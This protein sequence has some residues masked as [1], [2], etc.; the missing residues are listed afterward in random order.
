[1][2]R[3]KGPIHTI[4]YGVSSRD[5]PT[6]EGE[7]P[8]PSP[9]SGYIAKALDNHPIMRFLGSAG[10]AIL[11]TAVG[12]K[13]LKSGGLK[14]GMALEDSSR[15]AI[16]GGRTDALPTRLVKGIQE[17][18]AGLDELQSVARSVNGVDNPYERLVYEVDGKLTSGYEGIRSET[19]FWR[20]ISEEGAKVSGVGQTG[21][22]AEVWMY[23]DELQKRLVRAGRRMPYELPALYI[24]Q[25]GVTEPLFGHN[26]DR[27]K[28]NW[29][30]PADVVTD[31]VKQSTMNLATM[32]LPFEAL[33]A[34]GTAGKSSLTTFANS[35]ND[36]KALSPI[37]RKASNLAVDLRSLLAE[38]GQDS[39]VI[40]NKALKV[41]SRTS[42]AFATGVQAARDT[43]PEFVQALHSARHGATEAARSA[44]EKNAGKLKILTARAKG[45]F[46][47]N[48]QSDFGA[49]DSIPTFKGLRT[50]FKAAAEDF[51]T[52][53]VA[54]DVVSGKMTERQALSQVIERFSSPRQG[55][56]DKVLGDNK[57]LLRSKGMD[58]TDADRLLQNGINRIQAQHSS[59]LSRLAE[60]FHGLGHG[61]P[62]S[63]T[64]TTSEFFLKR[65]QD[66]YKDQLE[67]TLIRKNNIDPKAANNFVNNINIA[68]LPRQKTST[69]ITKRITLGRK[70]IQADGDEFF[71]DI[72][73]RFSK[74]KGGKTFSESIGEGSALRQSLER[75]DR[76]FVS[77][78]FQNGLRLDITKKW[79][80]FY[81]NDVSH[82]TSDIL[83]P[84]K[85]SYSDFVGE[86][87]P[88]KQSY[89]IR[90]T[91]QTLGIKLNEADGKAISETVLSSRIAA[92]GID[93][94]DTSYLRDYL[95]NNKGLTTGFFSGKA[96]L[97]GMKPLLI[98]EGMEAGI[99]NHLPQ[100]HQLAIRQIASAQATR[101]PLTAGLGQVTPTLGQS[102]I[103]GV[104]R[105]SNGSIL[106]FTQLASTLRNAKGFLADEFKLPIIGFN[107]ADM[108]G[109]KSLK[110]I[111]NS[112]PIQYI[113]ARTVQ[114]FLGQQEKQAADYFILA[115]N[116][117]T[118]GVLRSFGTNEQGNQVS[119]TIAGSFR[120]ISSSSSELI[121]KEARN[122]AKLRGSTSDE[123][124][125]ISNRKTRLKSLFDVDEEQPNSLF[126]LYNRF[127]GRQSDIRNTNVMARLLTPGE[128]V[129]YT[130]R[131]IR[132]TLTLKGLQDDVDNING[133]HTVDE[134]NAVVHTQRD[135]LNAVDE[136]RKKT[137]GNGTH[138]N[139]IK[140]LEDDKPNL[141]TSAGVKASDVSSGSDK[142]LRQTY[143]ALFDDQARAASIIKRRGGDPRE[144]TAALSR[145]KSHLGQSNLDSTS[146]LAPRSRVIATRKDEASNEV[147]RYI[148]LKNQML[149]GNA[150]E[151]IFTET[152]KAI[153][154]LQKQGRIGIND[155]IEAEA[156]ALASL[157]N[158]SA[159]A[160][161]KAEQ[162]GLQDARK[163]LIKFAEMVREKPEAA[164][165][166]K[167]Y[168][169]GDIAM[170]N[171]G[172]RRPFSRAM[173]A[174]SRAF[175]TAPYEVDDLA[176]NTLGSGQDH[177]IV[178]TFGTV[179]AKNPM[180]A[181]KSALG[182]GTYNNPES[183]STGSVPVSHLVSRVNKYF[184]TVGMQL[185]QSQYG[186][187]LDLYARGMVGKRILPAVAG[188]AT[189]L[190]ADRVVG[191]AVN[192]KD[193][194]GE[195]VYSPFL[196]TKLARGAVE[197]N[198]VGAG[199]IPGGMNAQEKREQLLNGQVPIKQGRY[200]PLGST[201]FMGG[202]T[203]YYR[204]SYYRKLKEAGTYT[205]D[206][207]GT[208]MEKLLYGYDFSPLRPLDPYRFER[209]HYEDRPYP[210][211]GEYFTGPWGPLN[212]VLNMT[213]GKLLKPQVTMHQ[214]ELAAG[215]ANYQPAGQ[216][217]AYEGSGIA[218]GGR[219]GLG[220][221][222]VGSK[223]YLSNSYGSYGG[224]GVGS[225]YG[226]STLA[227]GNYNSR[228]SSMAGP[229]GSAS[230]Q[231][232]AA[233]GGSNNALRNMAY[234]PPKISG[235]MPPEII[236]AGDPLK[237]NSFGV[238]SSELGYRV[239][240]MA[241]IYG[242]GF[243]SLRSSLGLGSKDLDPKRAVLQSASKG[244]GSTRSFW[245][246]NLGGLGDVPLA[247][248]GALG[249]IEA[250]EIIRRFI[251]KERSNTEYI[252][253]I[254]NSMGKKYPFLP[255]PEYF[256][257]FRTG[258][259]YT[260]V[261]DGELRLPG[262]GYERLNN[263]SKDSM[264]NYDR[265]S[266]LDILADVAP[267]STQFRSLNNQIEMGSLDPGEREKVKTIRE[268]VADT[269]HK[270]TFT[271]YK[272]KDSNP[273]GLALHPNVHAM[274]RIGEYI[275]HRDTFFNTKFLQKRTAT[276][277]WERRNVY[278]STFPEWQKPY[279]SFV[280]PTIEKATQRNPLVA[281]TAT[282]AFGSMFGR[283]AKAKT[284]GTVVGAMVG[285]GASVR[286]SAHE[287][288]TGER[289]M[290]KTRKKEIAL[291]EY[292]DMLSYVKNT[293][294]ANQA[295]QEGDVRSAMSFQNAAKRTM[296]GA[297][298][299][300]AS[301]ETLSLAI[302]K[303]KREHFRAMINAPEN[304]RPTIL[305]TAGRLERRIYESA[306][307]MKVEKKPELEE[308]FSEH[309]LPDS[310]WE[311]WQP[312]T[313]MDHVKIKTGQ[314][315]GL[316]M[317][318][319]GYFPQQIR[320]ANLTNP[321][322][323][324]FFKHGDSQDTAA[325]L[326]IMMSKMGI[327]GS[328][329]KS[330]NPYGSNSMNIRA[331][332]M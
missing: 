143:Q 314:S 310:Q 108:F 58:A 278:G 216:S 137:F 162:S 140:Y 139:I 220:D 116:K 286:G 232:I 311:G 161:S 20:P 316:D 68:E 296:Y 274:S 148:A 307:G 87:T 183:F 3:D 11:V 264:G 93:P 27:R 50:G 304:D 124:N 25:R 96:S 325:Q 77:E 131:G 146:Q 196:T 19:R 229:T 67:K 303:R 260:K 269:T 177:T 258:D 227:I 133:I 305:S 170:L 129:T 103:G 15:M 165:F 226:S 101:D 160:T 208:P 64:F 243:S 85:Q 319:M 245:D 119:Q 218:M 123:I 47:G 71:D 294:L 228:M 44:S 42:G 112:S 41:S 242:F 126:R 194:N 179:F 320:E 8:A 66:V 2:L 297:D 31:F 332:V 21:T 309:E 285:F 189:F 99:F 256:T 267:Y 49:L 237:P 7:E 222:I 276:E 247:G 86:I 224:G 151:D 199:L 295:K 38:V 317:S 36:I 159:Y 287:L 118:K 164:S 284:L 175:G 121:S 262:I 52:L 192:D 157:F 88:N 200:W 102:A 34:A 78:E 323:P 198:S 97:F 329:N 205:S 110:E 263:V 1:M 172:I 173:P 219:G 144:L 275:A 105:S 22:S 197:I 280:K 290:P 6:R 298:L 185:D 292:T 248:Q 250:S 225:G 253:P 63:E 18:R 169:N 181:I 33:G 306:W 166:L 279:E 156:S 301:L 251:P 73:K 154:V 75:V 174:F 288:I 91:A 28:L 56:L 107:P 125:G 81:R 152:S 210:V 109:Y 212:S 265:V 167:P 203:M 184:G 315:M 268:Q 149:Q 106:D 45:F 191:G 249:N 186:G 32:I 217:G 4:G 211:S 14:L 120:A 29:Y 127:K 214:Q 281:A 239:Q 69:D 95:L 241:G 147:F 238:Q 204:P 16:S 37:Q 113:S 257:N 300:N 40:I 74:I 313:D 70:S 35:M 115:R 190:A 282:A 327:S 48:S 261:S 171:T 187:P 104:Y 206:A 39:S 176:V 235:I 293:H 321:S 17:L 117:G 76:Q 182:V 9:N 13:F 153:R 178:P 89:L 254:Q 51:K 246:L 266:Q 145:V 322:Y 43:Q 59:S 130:Q 201:P 84:A 12:S 270:Y 312:T 30:N 326:R 259:P 54:H 94:N 142:T 83:K 223:S 57:N 271:P 318:Q 188:G 10:T 150:G 92:K 100:E 155:A 289:F 46:T 79:N 141:F 111:Q 80:S 331:G 272:Y 132:K 202:K 5:M 213:A 234:G 233:L 26:Q 195:R 180:G 330:A 136:F 158:F 122:A 98:D 62:N 53:G 61:G 60:G 134:K 128:E 324:S 207:N 193:K 72:L 138:R 221:G 168:A 55:I 302:P 82:I 24:A 328:V 308:Y 163:R 231:T 236:P 209:Q 65:Q 240:E 230:K 215:L 114:P 277:D 273:E 90:K 252:N 291:E 135:V 283:T 255:G 23:R 299:D 244:Y